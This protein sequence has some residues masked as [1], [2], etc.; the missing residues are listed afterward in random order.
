MK[1]LTLL[2]IGLTFMYATSHPPYGPGIQW[3]PIGSTASGFVIFSDITLNGGPVDGGE[4]SS[5]VSAGTCANNDCDI[6]GAMYNGLNI[7]WSYMP[8]D[9]AT[10]EITMSINLDD[11]TTDGVNG[12]YP[13]VTPGVYEPTITFNFYD[14]SESKMYYN[15]GSSLAPANLGSIIGIS[16]DIT[17]DGAHCSSDGF[18]FGATDYCLDPGA[19]ELS[20]YADGSV[21]AEFDAIGGGTD[22]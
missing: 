2:I 19:C 16:L 12:N 20:H 10:G 7:A 4:V 11:V 3:S 6:L 8:A 1:K 15:V 17:G 5:T 22:S 14:A 21:A 13:L 18:A 9:P